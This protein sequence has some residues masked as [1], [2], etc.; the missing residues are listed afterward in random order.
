MA[1]SGTKLQK[2]ALVWVDPDT[3]SMYPAKVDIENNLQVEV[4]N[5][6]AIPVDIISGGGGS[7]PAVVDTNNSTIATLGIGA[8]FTGTGTEVL[9]YRAIAVTIFADEDSA[10]DGMTFQFSTDNSNWDDV[11]AF[12]MVADETRRF[13][14]PVTAQYFRVV[15]T[16]GATGQ[17]AFRLETLLHPG[18]ILTSIHRVGSATSDDR[19]C[20]LVKAVIT[21]KNPGGNYVNFQA[22]T[23][24]NFKVSVEEFD[25]GALGQEL[26]AASVPVTIASDQSHPPGIPEPSQVLH[27]TITASG[28][29]S[30]VNIS[31]GQQVVVRQVYVATNEDFTPCTFDL[32]FNSGGT[33]KYKTR[34]VSVGSRI[35]N[36]TIV[37]IT[38]GD[39]EDFFINLDVADAN[40]EVTV[41]FDVV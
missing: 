26:M 37:P 6:D 9:E 2:V 10:A 23:A 12:N 41:V 31:G 20:E 14:L 3:G 25:S 35:P 36:V 24:G 22:T 15:Y 34:L 5:T 4:T 33:A 32:R 28:T 7:N 30:L 18:N 40:L 38:G 21:G 39:G 13:Q 27:Y 11:Y 16:N 17:G 1:G 29:T 8:T 19:S